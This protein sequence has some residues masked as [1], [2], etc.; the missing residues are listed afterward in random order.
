MQIDA[1]KSKGPGKGKDGKKGG[2]GKGDDKKK[3]MKCFWCEKT[4]TC[5]SRLLGQDVVRR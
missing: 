2:K 4:R 3:D 5:T 1:L